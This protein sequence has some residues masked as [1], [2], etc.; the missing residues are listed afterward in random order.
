M[1]IFTDILNSTSNPFSQV[2]KTSAPGQHP[3]P[4]QARQTAQPTARSL[5]KYTPLQ[6]APDMWGYICKN[7]WIW[8]AYAYI[9]KINLC[10]WIV[11]WYICF[12]NYTAYIHSRRRLALGMWIACVRHVKSKN[13]SM[14]CRFS[15][16]SQKWLL[17][18]VHVGLSLL[19]FFNAYFGP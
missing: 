2:K 15:S 11:P 19:H 12:D 5:Q 8:T 4:D 13:S 17:V 7:M 16:I 10:A 14:P 3:V 18:I 6:T 9:K 1:L